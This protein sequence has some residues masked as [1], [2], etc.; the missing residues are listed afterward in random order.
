LTLGRVREKM[1][2]AHSSPTDE[3]R[4]AERADMHEEVFEVRSERVP[5]ALCVTATGELD[6]T[7]VAVLEREVVAVPAS[8]SETLVILDIGA[9]TFID[10]SGINLLLRLSERFPKRLRLINGSPAVARVLEL[11]GLADYLPLLGSDA[12][13]FAPLP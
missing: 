6:L 11:T 7:T 4:T 13:P 10:S 2:A 1:R 5:G 8:D 12:D 3:G 9:L